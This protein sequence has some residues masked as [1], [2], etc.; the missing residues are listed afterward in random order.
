MFYTYVLKS[1]IN[2]FIYV[3]STANIQER[4][5]RHNSGKVRSTKAYKPWELVQIE[6][7][8]TRSEATKRELFLKTGQQKEALRNKYVDNGQVAKW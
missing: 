8:V 4:V 5:R 3:G 6:T 7:F 1:R 2:N